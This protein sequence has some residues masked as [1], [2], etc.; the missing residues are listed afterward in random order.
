MAPTVS[1]LKPPLLWKYFKEIL[2]I[3]H[4]SG[5]EK[6]LGDY[7]ISVAKQFNLEY[8][9]DNTGNVIVSKKATPGYEKADGVI[10]QSH[11][12]MVC[13]KNSD[14]QHDF[15]KDAIKMEID[16]EWA[17]ARGTTLGAD[18]GIGICTS[19]AIMES[20]N[21]VHPPLEFLFT[22][23]EETGLKGAS[24]LQPGV[25][26]G[27]KLLNLDSEDE[28]EF[29]IG[30]AG[31]ADSKIIFPLEKESYTGT[32][33][34][35]KLFGYQGGH[36]GVDINLGRGNAIKLLS[37]IL[38]EVTQEVP[39]KL[40]VIKGGNLRNAIPRESWAEI[41][42][43]SDKK[44]LF[45]KATQKAFYNIKDEFKAT[46]PNTEISLKK[47]ENNSGNVLS[48]HSQR[49]LLN[50]L[51]ALPHGVIS[52]HPEMERLVETSTN[53]AVI[54][55]LV[56]KAEIICS[57]RSSSASA[58]EA[59]R[60]ILAALSELTG[61]EI[62]QEEGYPGWKPNLKSPLLK[63]LKNI[64]KELFNQEAHVAAIHA[65]LEC[66]IIGDKF[67][68]MDMISFGP[69]IKFPHSP[70]E[71]VHIGSVEKYWEFLI[72]ILEKLK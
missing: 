66:G 16:G 40:A 60:N 23:E 15:T 12:D 71:K 7:I 51:L 54:N 22:I 4:G 41:I 63:S 20:N 1:N 13:E 42:L 61:S 27:K 46:D 34:Q 2:K 62:I 65:G 35:V 6:A 39:F 37:R 3:P 45:Q 58:L 59:A 47:S 26:K 25:L 50:L 9:R 48:A 68:G 19:L 11:L 18:N 33:Y 57:T 21:L 5:N 53:L 49:T 17:H 8:L 24:Q 70:G 28:G 10:L 44:D 29:T 36:S 69:T 52:M 55:T 30:C 14:I 43:G 38:W 31:G 32:H 72:K 67:P 64:Y 56:D